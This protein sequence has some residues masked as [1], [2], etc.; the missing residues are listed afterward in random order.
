M[1][2]ETAKYYFRIQGQT[3][4]RGSTRSASARHGGGDRY[5]SRFS[6]SS[7]LKTL[8]MVPTSTMSGARHQ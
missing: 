3:H 5:E 1:S 2:Y 7:K 4:N 8:K 6:I